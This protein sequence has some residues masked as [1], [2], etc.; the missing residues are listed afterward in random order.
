MA[1]NSSAVPFA[2]FN[3]SSQQQNGRAHEIDQFS[4]QDQFF[5]VLCYNV[6]EH[7]ITAFKLSPNYKN[8][9]IEHNN[10]QSSA[11]IAPKMGF[12]FNLSFVSPSSAEEK[13]GFFGP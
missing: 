13:T 8:V 11:K 7:A 9:L 6:K 4:Y 10:H 12:D 1:P 2:M 5:S 3:S